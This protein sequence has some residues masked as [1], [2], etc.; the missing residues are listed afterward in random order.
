M[1][2]L[3]KNRINE[4]NISE[5]D[6]M[7]CIKNI[8]PYQSVLVYTSYMDGLGTKDSDLDVYVIY[9]DINL[10]NNF[11][12]FEKT[13]REVFVKNDLEIDIEYRS[14]SEINLLIDRFNNTIDADFPL[15]DLKLLYRLNIGEDIGQREISSKVKSKIKNENFKKYL[16]KIYSSL[17]KSLFYD[18]LDLYNDKDYISSV[19]VGRKSLE[20][21]MATLSVTKGY[22]ILKDKWTLRT[23]IKSFCHDNE[24]LNKYLYFIVYCTVNESTIDEYSKSLLEFLEENISSFNLSRI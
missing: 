2:Q 22:I 1:N 3:L 21:L 11:K 10:S 17:A 20:Y 9:D 7:K 19:I 12:K 15:L 24:I 5:S 23:F 18:S 16:I 6:I 13:L 8:S 14:I 4:H